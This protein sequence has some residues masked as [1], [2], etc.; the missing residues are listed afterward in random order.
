MDTEVNA[1][2]DKKCDSVLNKSD[3]FVGKNYSFKECTTDFLITLE[4]SKIRFLPLY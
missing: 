1:T 3:G 2:V 4:V